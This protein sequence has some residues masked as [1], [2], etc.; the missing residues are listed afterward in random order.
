MQKVFFHFYFFLFFLEETANYKSRIQA[1]IDTGD[2][3]VHSVVYMNW[4][5]LLYYIRLL[6]LICFKPF[7]LSASFL[8]CK[9]K[10]IKSSFLLHLT[11][12]AYN[13]ALYFSSSFEKSSVLWMRNWSLWKR[14]TQHKQQ[15]S[16]TNEKK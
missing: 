10:K 6:F 4:I 14:C 5:A 7:F 1:I 2:G 12:H 3:K 9:T 11:M 16:S 15:L 8:L 13:F